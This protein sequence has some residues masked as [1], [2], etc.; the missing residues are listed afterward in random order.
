MQPGRGLITIETPPAGDGR[1]IAAAAEAIAAVTAEQL[2]QIEAAIA[3]HT[4]ILRQLRLLRRR[5][6]RKV[7]G[8]G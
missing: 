1:Q 2:P 4:E 7:E 3:Q 8:E 6:T 5:L